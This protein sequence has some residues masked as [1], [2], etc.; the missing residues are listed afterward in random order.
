[1]LRLARILPFA[2]V[3]LLVGQ[4]GCKLTPPTDDDFD[5]PAV[6]QDD[7]SSLKGRAWK[8]ATRQGGKEPVARDGVL[9][10]RA[11]DEGFGVAR[12]LVELRKNGYYHAFEARMRSSS[13][14][15]E[16]RAELSLGYHEGAKNPVPVSAIW[17]VSYAEGD[18]RW[19]IQPAVLDKDL[20]AI[21]SGPTSTVAA[22]EFADYRVELDLLRGTITWWVDGSLFWQTTREAMSLDNKSGPAITHFIGGTTEVDSARAERLERA[23]ELRFDQVRSSDRSPSRVEVLFSLRDVDD[24]PIVIARARLGLDLVAEVLENGAPLDEVESP[25][26]LR[27]AEEL[28]L[29]LVLVLDYTESMRAAGGGTG[30]E[31][32]RDA[33]RQLIFDRADDHRIAVVEF[34]DNQA[35]DNYSTLVDFTTNK[36][37]AWNAV[38][39][40][41]P[42]HG[43]SSA[44]DAID[45][46]LELFPAA[47]D[48]SRVTVLAFLS[49]GF[50]TASVATPQT[51]IDKAIARDVRIF[52][53]GVEDVRGVD[54]LELERISSETGG[55]YFQAEQIDQLVA[56]FDDID[57]ELSSQYKVAYVTPQTGSFESTLWTTVN[58]TRVLIPIERTIDAAAISGD[59]REGLL[60][61]GPV[62][63]AS[64]NASFAFIGEHTPRRISALRFQFDP[65][66]TPITQD[67]I[68]VSVDPTGPLA[69]WTVVRGAGDWWE[70]S[71]PEIGFGDFG[72]YFEVELSNIG[73]GGFDLPFIWDNSLYSNGVLFFGGDPGDLI[74]GNWQ[75]MVSIP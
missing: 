9:K 8:A 4:A 43:F 58:G 69:A 71:G 28:D 40:Y 25:V 64:G 1:V 23:A 66:G 62:E 53:V 17:R 24:A 60:A 44:W 70:A 29:D 42:F 31:T 75:S 22:G 47:P 3:G 72:R 48:S 13:T 36:W 74:G 68:L 27:G 26:H 37:V 34:H 49:D 57:A 21:E 54:E 33:A 65:S 46:G 51:I 19:T 11:E 38:R 50:D 18:A 63:A 61:V 5:F 45:S 6:F 67:D 16:S 32:M 12:S 59:T 52:N 20:A 7:F 35:G 2:L 73:A 39:D 55:R 56:R 14:V 41:E 10:L 30:I 15:D